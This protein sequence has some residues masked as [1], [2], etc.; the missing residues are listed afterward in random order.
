MK[1]IGAHVSAAGGVE[2]APLNAMAIG[3]TAFA[4]FTKNQRQ[5]QA[6]PLTENSILSFQQNCQKAGIAPQHILV[7]DSYLINIGHPE[8]AGLKKSRDAFVDEFKRCEQ[9]G[10]PLLNFHPGSSL[11]KISEK[12]CMDTIAESIDLALGATK[13]VV[14]VIENTAGQG[15]NIGYRFEHLAYM[16][17]RVTDKARIGICL[18]TAH[19]FAAGYDLL[20]KEACELTFRQFDTIVGLHYLCGMH[21]NDSKRDLGS[22]VD[23]HD[24]IGFGLLGQ[25]VF[26]FIMQ[27][28]RFD[29]LP[30]IL[31][32]PRPELWPEEIRSLK[33]LITIQPTKYTK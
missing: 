11:N 27:N 26:K 5:W 1:R 9:L 15:S 30:L 29:D 13:N 31:E 23:R 21:L 18:D 3:A 19:L 6:K 20:T 33:S 16:I 22:R 7:H 8:R 12:E 17:D 14:A 32:T 4:L 10:L 2:N 28:D 24:S 25:T